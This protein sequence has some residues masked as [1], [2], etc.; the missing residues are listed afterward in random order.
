[1]KISKLFDAGF[2]DPVLGD[3]GKGK[4]NV[5]QILNCQQ[6][7]FIMLY[8]SYVNNV[9]LKKDKEDLTRRKSMSAGLL[10]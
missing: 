3:I 8:S 2:V 9:F 10:L 1:M 5:C 6:Y 7:L 4:D